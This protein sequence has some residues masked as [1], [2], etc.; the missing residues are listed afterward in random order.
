MDRRFVQFLM[1]DEIISQREKNS[2]IYLPLGPL[3]WHGP[4]LPLGVDPLRAEIAA[5]KLA[6]ETDGIVLPTLFVG[7]ER[8]RSPEMLKNIGFKGNEYIVG[9]DFP[10]NTLPSLYFKEEVF[11]VL[12]R[13]YLE[14][15][16]DV[17]KFKNIV[18]INGHGGGN[19]KEVIERLRKEFISTRNVKILHLMPMLD[20]TLGIFHSGHATKEETETLMAYYPESVDIK[21]LPEKPSSLYNIKYAIVDDPTFN[22]KP[23]TDFTVRGEE[24]PR[25]SD[26]ERGKEIFEKTVKQMKEV[27]MKEIKKGGEE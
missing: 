2:L 23:S 12:L 25:D 15:I 24:D 22:G 19:H 8:E 13:N 6:Q 7:T 1:P 5:L 3:E 16:I 20:F 17:W 14:L 9:M 26:K 11:A 27:I 18:I 4:H 21:K 10:E